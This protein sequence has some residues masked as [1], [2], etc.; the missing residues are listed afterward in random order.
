L[1]PKAFRASS[2]RR[3]KPPSETRGRIPLQGDRDHLAEIDEEG[4]R[5]DD[6]DPHRR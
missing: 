3:K 4:I 1:K 6:T 5:A 2:E